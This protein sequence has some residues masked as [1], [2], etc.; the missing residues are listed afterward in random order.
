MSDELAATLAKFA[1]EYAP[2]PITSAPFV[3]AQQKEADAQEGRR[4]ARIRFAKWGANVVVALG[5]VYLL[6]AI[7]LFRQPADEAIAAEVAKTA[8]TVLL[9]N[10]SRDRPL[11]IDHAVAIL[12]EP[13]DARYR[14]Y[15]A[16]VTLRLREPLYGPAVTNGTVR[17]RMLQESVQL[18]RSTELKLDLF[19]DND[20]PA[21]PDMPRLIQVL[22]RGGEAMVVRVPFEAK[23]FGWKWRIEAPQ[24]GRREGERELDGVPLSHFESAPYL[25]FGLPNTMETIRARTTAARDYLVAVAKASQR[26][27]AG[28]SP[29]P[30]P[31]DP[32]RPAV[33]PAPVLF[34][35]GSLP[36]DPNQPAVEPDPNQPAVEPNALLPGAFQGIDPNKP[37]TPSEEP[38]KA[39]QPGQ[40]Y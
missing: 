30:E 12:R 8:Q 36:F 34:P 4:L 14:R 35:A 5:V 33:Q 26:Q 22:H 25:I 7:L 19:P 32:D 18:A 39:R 21:L 38:P 11:K 37:P 9:L 2:L 29:R 20:G 31:F 6:A 13:V 1:A 23:K 16:E 27:A 10:A 15:Y 24:L 28:Q 3:S 40:V 17:Y